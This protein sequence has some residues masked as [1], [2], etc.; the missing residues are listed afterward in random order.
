MKNRLVQLCMVLLVFKYCLDFGFAATNQTTNGTLN[1][2]ASFL[3]LLNEER[4]G[5][6][7]CSAGD[8][9]NDGFGDFLIGTFHNSTDGHDAGAVYLILG[10]PEIDWGMKTLLSEADA[11]FLGERSYEA[12][13]FSIA[14]Q[15]DVNGDGINDIVIGAPAGNDKVRFRPGKIYIVLGRETADWGYDCYLINNANAA[16]EGENGQD[17]AGRDV[18]IIKDLNGD[19]CDE[20]LCSAPYNDYG[21][22]DAGKVYLLLGKKDGW[23]MVGNLADAQASFF[24]SDEFATCGYSIAAIGDINNDGIHDFAIGAPGATKVF[25]M[26]GNPSVNWGRNFNL[27]NAD[28]TIINE[29]V[30]VRDE[31]GT[32]VSAAG[33]V[34]GDNISDFIISAINNNEGGHFAGKVYL[35]FGRS[36]WGGAEFSLA[37]TNASYIGEQSEDQAGWGLSGAGDINGDGFSDFLIGAWKNSYGY[38]YSGK[39]YLIYGQSSGWQQNVDLSNISL[40]FAGELDTN[41]AGYAVSTAGDV[42]GDGWDDFIVS[43][44]YSNEVAKWSGQ[45]YL[46]VDEREKLHISGNVNYY[47][48]SQPVPNSII[49]I[50]SNRTVVDTTDIAG[51][52][53]GDVY[54]ESDYSIIAQKNKNEDIGE[55]AISA[56]DAAMVARHTVKI[57]NLTEPFL[58]SADVNHDGNITAFDA[59]LIL[60]YA[61][62]DTTPQNSCVG[63]WIFLPDTIFITNLQANLDFQNFNA[64]IRGD[65]N[66]DWNLQYQFPKIVAHE[67]YAAE[68]IIIAENKALFPVQFESEDGMLSFDIKISYN[69]VVFEFESLENT[70]LASTFQ[71][72]FNESPEGVLR[73]CGY[74]LEP[75][76]TS[77]TYFN[78]KFNCQN[79]AASQN[80]ISIQSRTNDKPFA[81]AKILIESTNQLRMNLFQNS[82][83]VNERSCAYKR[84]CF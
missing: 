20:I 83:A 23:S 35:L 60:K 6:V 73:I 15:G 29:N 41:Y 36:N 57:S 76:M 37:A 31:L 12:V 32:K 72:N 51:Y 58:N 75:V 53:L 64:L 54:A 19:G 8:I 69:P 3:G 74:T 70:A 16:Y 62:Q 10:R 52:Y 13:G 65:V 42:N 79:S 33:D 68:S 24:Y 63:E 5:Y 27:E 49:T 30:F 34:N 48:T 77:G 21:A 7:L 26:F 1:P 38:T 17:L 82:Q 78:V 81:T 25:V 66:G 11:R 80:Y 45:V 40:F 59:V 71:F 56:Y 46:F 22:G 61:L 44:T 67:S 55:L 9:N 50:K 84:V 14:G 18:A 47:G 28:L 4:V 43:S 39:A 2:D